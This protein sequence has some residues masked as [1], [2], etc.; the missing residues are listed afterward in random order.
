MNGEEKAPAAAPTHYEIERRVEFKPS[1]DGDVT[2]AWL[3]IGSVDANGAETALRTWSLEHA[4][5]LGDVRGDLVLRAIPS[6]R[7]TE[8]TISIAVQ[9]KVELG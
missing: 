5:E 2:Y 6:S 8:R 9:R 4:T 3:E 1:A 7:I